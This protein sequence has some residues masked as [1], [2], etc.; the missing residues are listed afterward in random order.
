[1]ADFRFG[2]A[3]PQPT[4]QMMAD[5][6][7]A[8]ASGQQLPGIFG[9]LQTLT[10]IWTQAPP[11]PGAGR[12]QWVVWWCKSLLGSAAAI[13]AYRRARDP[14]LTTRKSDPVRDYLSA[15][16]LELVPGLAGLSHL[17]YEYARGLGLETQQ[18]GTSESVMH[19]C[20]LGGVRVSFA[21][22]A[23]PKGEGISSDGWFLGQGPYVRVDQVGPFLLAL[24]DHIWASEG[25][26][27][28]QLQ[29]KVD[30]HGYVSH[31][32]TSFGRAENY[33]STGAAQAWTDVAQL[34]QRCN[35][36]RRAGLSRRILFYGP[37]GT[38]KTTL[39]RNLAR[40]VGGGRTLRVE[41]QHMQGPMTSSLAQFLHILRPA[42]LLFD[43]LDRNTT[44]ALELLHYLED[45]DAHPWAKNLVLVGTVNAVDM[46]DPALLRPG[47][48]DEV[49]HVGEPS[50]AHRLAIV[51]HY[52]RRFELPQDP[53]QLSARM[54]GWTPADVR[55]VVACL[56]LVGLEHLDAEVE[57][58][59]LQRNLH[60][61]D[62]VSRFLARPSTQPHGGTR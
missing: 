18:I 46:L 52:C 38:G 2:S 17:V 28:L 41:L 10:G 14:G 13:L 11:M 23:D 43:D 32:L 1:V 62:A 30:S 42:V 16:G 24:A 48:F 47:R 7:M 61:G 4:G 58:V 36:F 25:H 54:A 19:V 15:Q 50:D 57:R 51:E 40:Q 3:G 8:A 33:V 49:R 27:D 34:A 21:F 55:E 53:L 9:L 59:G 5:A 6:L 26:H 56:A 35:A 31:R 29:G 37:P 45:L 44:Q 12:V 22:Y 60:S 39:A 20:E